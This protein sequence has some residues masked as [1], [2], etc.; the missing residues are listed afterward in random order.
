MRFAHVVSSSLLSLS[1]LV[2]GALPIPG[3]CLLFPPFHLDEYPLTGNSSPDKLPSGIDAD[4]TQMDLLGNTIV[5]TYYSSYY[6]VKVAPIAAKHNMQLYLGVFMTS[7]SWYQDQIN[8]AVAAVKSNPS[9]VKAILVGN[10]NVVPNGPYTTD[11]IISQMKLVRDRVKSET[12]VS[13]PVG[14]VQRTNEWPNSDPGMVA[15]A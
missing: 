8:D 4:L 14:T 11:Y 15:L 2:H 7:E 9:T 5:R 6:G 12:G 10:E 13:V 3:A 1:A